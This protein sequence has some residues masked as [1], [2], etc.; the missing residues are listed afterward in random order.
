MIGRVET[1]LYRG[2]GE[3]WSFLASTWPDLVRSQ[4]LRVQVSHSEAL[5]L[6]CRAAIAAA[7]S[8][9]N[10]DAPK[11]RKLVGVATSSL[12]RLEK[13]THPW[14]KPFARLVR[15]GLATLAGEKVRAVDDLIAAAAGFDALGM[16]LY[17]AASRRR[18]GQLLEPLDGKRFIDDADAWMIS[19]GIQQPEKFADVL[20]PGV[21]D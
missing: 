5:H 17:A 15:A 18:R 10:G 11:S 14:S 20:V 4:L 3:A 9:C 19:Q 2:D 7:A 8:P 16:A 6:R 1:S 21:W 13:Q 12:R